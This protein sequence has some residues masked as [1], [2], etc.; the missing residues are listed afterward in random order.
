MKPVVIHPDARKEIEDSAAYYEQQRPGLGR[1]FRL[2]FE[3]ALGRIIDFPQLYAIEEEDYR[4]CPM[5]RFP[6]TLYYADLPQ[7]LWLVAVAHQRRKPGYWRRRRR[8]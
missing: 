5:H 1:E 6:Y 7:H 2:E 3:I 4:A 8:N